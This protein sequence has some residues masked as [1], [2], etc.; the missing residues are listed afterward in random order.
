MTTRVHFSS[1]L[2][3]FL[4]SPRPRSSLE[5]SLRSSHEATRLSQAVSTSPFLPPLRLS[6]RVNEPDRHPPLALP[7][8][9]PYHRSAALLN[10]SET[11]KQALNALASEGGERSSET[12]RAL[13]PYLSLSTLLLLRQTHPDA[14]GPVISERLYDLLDAQRDWVVSPECPTELRD[15]YLVRVFGEGWDKLVKEGMTAIAA[16]KKAEIIKGLVLDSSKLT[17]STPQPQPCP[18]LA[19]FQ[20]K[21]KQTTGGLLEKRELSLPRDY[22]ARSRD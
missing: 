6:A 20:Q 15:S 16:D 1:S 7:R 13:L 5:G 21:L 18:D 11:H 2:L 8:S 10:T 22:T 3:V 12:L 19:T 17:A 14:L 4:R 9:A